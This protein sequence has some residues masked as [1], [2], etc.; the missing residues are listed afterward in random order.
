MNIVSFLIARYVKTG[1]FGRAAALLPLLGKMGIREFAAGSRDVFRI[2]SFGKGY[3]ERAGDPDCRDSIFPITDRSYPGL[4]PV[5][6]YRR[7]CRNTHNRWGLLAQESNRIHV[8]PRCLTAGSWYCKIIE[9][10]VNDHS[11][12]YG[13]T[14]SERTKSH[15]PFFFS[16]TPVS[17]NIP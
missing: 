16:I 9:F 6:R 7:R 1:R 17:R 11:G 10:E 4:H 2:H 3:K 15:F 5:F 8:R 13:L 12:S 14:K